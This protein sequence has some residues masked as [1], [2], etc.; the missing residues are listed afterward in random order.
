MQQVNFWRTAAAVGLVILAVGVGTAGGSLLRRATASG[1]PVSPC[2]VHF[3]AHDPTASNWQA[4][5]AALQTALARRLGEFRD[6]QTRAGAPAVRAQ[7][8][9]DW[10]MS[11]TAKSVQARDFKLVDSK[12]LPLEQLRRCFDGTFAAPVSVPNGKSLAAFDG[13]APALLQMEL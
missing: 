13:R 5:A 11:V 9:L 3:Q 2:D 4:P 8:L 12:G 10:N 1:T 6:C 7:M